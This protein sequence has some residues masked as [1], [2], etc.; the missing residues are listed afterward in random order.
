M[1]KPENKAQSYNWIFTLT[2]IIAL[3]Y[4]PVKGFIDDQN[5]YHAFDWPTFSFPVASSYKANLKTVYKHK[6]A[7][8]QLSLES[9]KELSE[10]LEEIPF[11][12]ANSF[13]LHIFDRDGFRIF[14][15]RLSSNEFS[16]I[17]DKNGKVIAYDFQSDFPISLTDYKTIGSYVIGARY[18]LPEPI[19][20]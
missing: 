7:F 17:I 14:S 18:L 1:S 11:F 19:R 16:R 10:S 15:K 6:Q 4:F 20:D 13:T 2:V 8:Y 9:K 3:F 5:A 12:S